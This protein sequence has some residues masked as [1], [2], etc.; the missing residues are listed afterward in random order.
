MTL[1]SA[2]Y[3]DKKVLLVTT[4]DI[5]KRFETERELIQAG[6]MAT[7]GEMSTGIAHE[8][9][10]PLS[11][12]KTASDFILKKTD[13]KATIE[14][15]LFHKLLSKINNNVDR[16]S[17]IIEHMRQFARKSDLNIEDHASTALS[18]IVINADRINSAT[19]R[20]G[21]GTSLRPAEG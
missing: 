21:G 3:E 13:Q 6:K 19:A 7:L 16:A 10:Q 17:K 9:N 20:A 18:R 12:I 1:N 2:E 11:V 8:L 5:T 14:D 4:S 15:S